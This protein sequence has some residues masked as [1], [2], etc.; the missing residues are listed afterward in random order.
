[1]AMVRKWSEEV[2]FKNFLY[3]TFCCR[4]A[5]FLAML[6]WRMPMNGT[7]DTIQSPNFWFLAEHDE[8]LLK[9][10]AQAE[11]LVFAD[12]N[13]ALFKVRLFGE[14]LTKQVAVRSAVPIYEGDSALRIIR[15]LDD[16]GLLTPK[17]NQVLH[18]LRKAGNVAV[19]GLEG[20]SQHALDALRF[21][22][23]LA[24][25]FHRSFGEEKAFD[26]GP[27]LPPA[28]P[29]Q[30]DDALA[31]ELKRL[32]RQL[33]ETEQA[34]QEAQQ[35]AEEA[36]QQ[37]STT[38]ALLRET[39]QQQTQEN[40]RFA[41]RLGELQR[42]TAEKTQDEINLT[43]ATLK[44]VA[45]DAVDLDE[46]DTRKLIDDQLR[47]A[48]WEADTQRITF[49]AG[50][51]PQKGRNLAI[52]EWPTATGPA[53]YVLF[54]GITPVATVEAKRK[55][56]D[57][58]AAIK[59]AQRYSKGYVIK[60]EEQLPEG[61][62]WDEHVIPILLSSNGRPFL[63][64][65]RTKSGIWFRDA[66][67]STNL[68]RPL[69]AWPTPQG[70]VELLGQDIP[71]ADET[72]AKDSSDYLDLRYYQHEA[73]RAIED[74]IAKGE[75]NILTAMATGTGKTRTC[76]G[77]VY[78]LCKAKRFRRVLFLVDR[79]SLGEQTADAF[80]DF[81]LE[82][83]QTFNDI[84]DVKELGDIKPDKDTR[85][86][87]ATIQGMIKRLLFSNGDEQPLP[88]D[89]YDC[90]IVDECHRGYNL[91]KDMSEAELTFRSERD[92]ISKYSRVLD[93]FDAVR[94]G[95]TAT[96]ALHTTELFG[97]PVY[98]YSYRQ[99]VIDGYLVDH[100][101][102]I[103]IVTRLAED[104]ITWKA[105]EEIEV[106][107]VKSGEIDT[108]NLDDEVSVEVE[109]FNKRVITEPFNKAVCERL[110]KHL[111]PTFDGKTL[112]F[113][114][115]DSHA[116]MVVDLLKQAFCYQY[117]S[118]DD[119]AVVKIT[120]TA[121]KP[122]ELIRYFKNEKM[123][124][125]V[126]TVDLLT[127]GID[128]PKITNLVFLRRVRSRILY[129]QMMG[130]A[131]RLCDEIGKEC[132]RIFDAVDLYS[133]IQDYSTMKP[134]VQN[135]SVTFDQLIKELEEAEAD[136]VRKTVID[137][138]R[139]KFQ[140]K[141]RLLMGNALEKFT[142]I[143]GGDAEQFAQKLAETDL[144]A[145]S[146]M[147]TSL[148]GLGAFLDNLRTTKR[149][150]QLISHHDD[151]VLREERGYG[152]S[153]KPKDYLDAFRQYI[154][155]HKNDVA[156]IKVVLQRP[157]DLTRQ[158]LRELKLLLD[159]HGYSEVKLRTAWRDATNQD[160]AASIIG[161]IRQLA[162]GSPLVPYQKRV[163]RAMERILASRAW[164]APQRQWL[165]RIGAQMRTETIV[166]R[167]SLNSGQFRAD[168]GF[169]RL[170]KVFDGRMDEVL[171]E[172]NEALWDEVG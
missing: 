129:E 44:T 163:E 31:E 42:R 59:Q 166:D 87:I 170:D 68:A 120:G 116:D 40:A 37:L 21:A 58:S 66:R 104:G 139:A 113:C 169:K 128:V 164:T 43:K 70:L 77:L 55:R 9:C 106:L 74:A 141:K 100:E 22:R 60:G 89:Q 155:T 13:A 135:P 69:T 63:K 93:H 165:E 117:G 136:D 137:Q 153:V 94:V 38:E 15:R 7:S 39:E 23:I 65:V 76:I 138:F 152:N 97:E 5:M 88:V 149:P 130:R 124:N 126:V 25:W 127:T 53:D 72:L 8:L 99:A 54:V 148:Q 75:R 85:L 159:E 110:A 24:I 27:F 147:L 150:K 156:A 28:K 18:I 41:E 142:T 151:E 167:E 105:G 108:W 158:Q 107:D 145:T 52:A 84:Y 51:R 79:T 10:A 35:R 73:I 143:T 119:D 81:R 133:A 146:R 3:R 101:P 92:Y 36:Y 122:L 168:G 115:T 80:K 121:D 90:V 46:A 82:S 78:R 157:R 67:V 102:P 172:I 125:V 132:F 1:M 19:H 91:D 111:D 162:L 32:R 61:G 29:Q 86:Q 140:R 20:E 161:F 160:I 17:I 56:V 131:T 118:V 144:Q 134:V 154:E 98:T 62:P 12:P 30:A 96:P 49:K 2:K 48:G 34:Q 83:H 14:L 114:A 109:E 95:L 47:D 50:V 171:G 6:D 103:R 33:A 112:I 4:F 64:Q 57:V 71:E 123:P 26:P 11:R 16:E 45:E